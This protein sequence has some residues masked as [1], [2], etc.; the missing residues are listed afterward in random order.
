MLE[1][2]CSNERAYFGID[3]RMS[4]LASLHFGIDTRM[5]VLAS[6]HFGIDT[7]MSVLASLDSSATVLQLESRSE[8]PK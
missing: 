3:T 4:V 2:A 1:R 7:R 8:W 6:L 5:S